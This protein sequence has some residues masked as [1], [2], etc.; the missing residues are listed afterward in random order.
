LTKS[1][2]LA[3]ATPGELLAYRTAYEQF[4]G[5]VSWST[6]FN[7]TIRLCEKGFHVSRALAYA[8]KQNKQLILNDTQLREVFVK[9]MSTNEVYQE[10]DRMKRIKLGRT[11]RRISREGIET[12]YNGSLADQIIDE[13]QKKGLENNRI[14]K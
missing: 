13:I 2:P 5:G 10:G 9:N 12:F 11:L 6:L 8:I 14:E 4:G 1:G 3:I 7:P